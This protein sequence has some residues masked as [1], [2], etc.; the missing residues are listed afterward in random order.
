MPNNYPPQYRNPSNGLGIAGFIVSLV[1]LIS[2]GL[3]A[4]VGLIMSIIAM[5]REPRGFAIAGLILGILGSLWV[6]VAVVFVIVMGGL[7]AAAAA[8]GIAAIPHAAALA[9]M[10][11]LA[12]Q[13]EQYR[14]A[15]GT[16][17]AAVSQLPNVTNE[18][19]TDPW[20]NAYL[21][22]PDA[23]GNGFTLVSMGPDGQPSTGDEIDFRSTR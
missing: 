6:L 11:Q 18:Q 15:N 8:V 16:L 4:P 19:I 14:Q 10:A 3:I 17:P 22:V 5:R 12:P 20:G 2:C 1:G 9:E 7:V 21:I 23:T 13:V